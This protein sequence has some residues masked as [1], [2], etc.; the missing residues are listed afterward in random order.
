MLIWIRILHII[1]K[2]YT[3]GEVWA[4]ME[5]CFWQGPGNFVH[6]LSKD[7]LWVYN[8]LNLVQEYNILEY[9]HRTDRGTNMH[10]AKKKI[11]A[12]KIH[13]QQ[14]I[15]LHL[16][17]NTLFFDFHFSLF[18]SISLSKVNNDKVVS[19][20]LFNVLSFAYNRCSCR[21]CSLMLTDKLFA[22]AVTI[23]ILCESRM[24]SLTYQM[25]ISN[26]LFTKHF[27]RK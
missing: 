9:I 22:D 27:K 24:I 12:W 8:A 10:V 13:D 19:N 21:Q 4:V 2:R 14:C 5:L 6:A 16:W 17:R 1:L 11:K 18:L 3:V 26:N 25:Y 20:R 15:H 7:V 23:H